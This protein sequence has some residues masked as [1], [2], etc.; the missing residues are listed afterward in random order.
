MNRA[1]AVRRRC[2]PPRRT[3]TGA[4]VDKKATDDLIDQVY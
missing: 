1:L 2:A 4:E 3:A